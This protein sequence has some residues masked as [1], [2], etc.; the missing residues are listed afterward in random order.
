ML[1]RVVEI[2]GSLGYLG[3]A[4]LMFLET[5]VPPIPSEAILPLAGFAVA[6][7]ELHL[8]GVVAA[9]A[10]GALL[11]ALPWYYLGRRVGFGRLG[12][13]ADRYG[14][15]S[16]LSAA[17]VERANCWFARRGALAVFVCRLVPGIR[18]WISLPAGAAR[19]PLAKFVL[20]S[21]TGTLLWTVLLVWAGYLL[22]SN[23]LQ[24]GQYLGPAG[25]AV[26]IGV[27]AVLVWRLAGARIMAL[28]RLAGRSAKP[29][30]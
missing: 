16:G 4:G 1:E 3:I 18:T 23:Y 14:R 25:N 10:A 15:W 22:G 7:G 11:G 21:G 28:M 30:S 8:A 29:R 6:R 17:V 9:G 19:M 5:I 26:L 2:V 24:V 12:K 20:Y 13:W 27:F